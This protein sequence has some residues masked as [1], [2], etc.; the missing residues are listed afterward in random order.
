MGWDGKG[1]VGMRMGPGADADVCMETITLCVS[2]CLCVCVVWAPHSNSKTWTQ[3]KW[4]IRWAVLY[5]AQDLSS[6]Q[7]DPSPKQACPATPPAE[8]WKGGAV[9]D[10]HTGQGETYLSHCVPVYPGLQA[11]LT[12][13]P[14]TAQPVAKL[15]GRQEKCFNANRTPWVHCFLSQGPDSMK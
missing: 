15:I 10:G 13:P 14:S 4:F 5:F 8:F 3:R 9:G 11:H 12:A 7:W 1:H 2:V 6:P